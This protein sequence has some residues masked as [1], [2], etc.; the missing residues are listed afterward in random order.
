[1]VK[2][3][4]KP[5]NKHIR[6]RKLLI[7]RRMNFLIE[8]Y[9]IRKN[10]VKKKRKI[11]Y[12]CRVCNKH[13]SFAAPLDNK[14]IYCA[15]H[16]PSYYIDV[17]SKYCIF[18]G[19]FKKAHYAKVGSKKKEYCTAHVPDGNYWSTTSE[20]CRAKNC[21]DMAIYGKTYLSVP[22]FCEVHKPEGYFEVFKFKCI[23]DLNC[24]IRAIY[25][26]DSNSL[27]LYCFKHHPESYLNLERYLRRKNK[28]MKLDS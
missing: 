17:R 8:K 16:K 20:R 15:N 23:S 19:C 1:M 11:T 9:N 4:F 26:M 2:G 10:F 24:N 22:K 13:A 6:Q 28:I 7:Q 18:Y 21:A 12:P 25:S 3:A 14:P 27:P 5:E